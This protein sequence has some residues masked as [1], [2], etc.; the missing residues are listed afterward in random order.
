MSNVIEVVVRCEMDATVYQN[1]E[2]QLRELIAGLS[3]EAGPGETEIVDVLVV[4]QDGQRLDPQPYLD[5]L[6][7]QQGAA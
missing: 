3:G 6:I 4:E 5:E 2:W 1:M 7:R